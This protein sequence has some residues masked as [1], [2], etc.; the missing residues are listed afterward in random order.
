[1]YQ[2]E[3]VETRQGLSNLPQDPQFLCQNVQRT[4][5]RLSKLKNSTFH[6]WSGRLI[7]LLNLPAYQLKVT[8]ILTSILEKDKEPSYRTKYP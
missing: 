7:T 1:M 4:G 3:L 2:V 5:I 6:R 8:Q